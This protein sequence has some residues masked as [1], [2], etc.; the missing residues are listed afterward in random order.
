MN[1]E[2][3]DDRYPYGASYSPLM[4]PEEEWDEDLRLMQEAHLNLVR[5]GDVH[6]SWDRLEPDR[7]EYR[8]GVLKRFYRKAAE[9]EIGALLSTGASCPPLWLAVDHPDVRLL[10]SRGERY[11]LGS[12][13]HWACIHHPAFLEASDRYL[14]ALARE[15][16]EFP[17]HFGWQ[18]SNEIGFPFNPTREQDTLDLY[19]YCE[20]C[21]E[22]FQGWLRD[23]YQAKDA[24]TEAWAWGTTNFVYRSWDEASPPESLPAS[25]SGVTRWIDWRLFW[26]D[27]FTRFARRQHDLLGD[28]DPDH[29]TSI[30]TF[31]FKGYDRF[32]TFTGLDQWKLAEVVDHIGYDLYPGSGDKLSSRPEHNSIFLDHGRSVSEITGK[33]YWLHEV[34]SGPIGGWLLGPDHNTDERDIL[35]YCLEGLGHDVKLMLYM[36]WKEWAYQPL[37]WGALVDLKG[38]PTSRWEAAGTLGRF[39]QEQADFLKDAH[40]PR[41]QVAILESKPN[42]I[43]LRGLDQE[44]LLFQA[45]RGAYRAFWE[46]GFQVDFLPTSRLEVTDLSR[47]QV[48]CLP[49]LGLLDEDQAR[50]L[51]TYVAGGGVLM[52]FARTASLD[53]RGWYHPELPVP[54]LGEALGLEVVRPDSAGGESLRFRGEDYRAW[55]S[56]DLLTPA[57][58]TEVAAQFGDG[59]PAVTLARYGQGLGVYLATQADLGEILGSEENVLGPVVEEVEKIRGIQPSIRVLSAR[60]QRPELDPHLLRTGR[61]TW[62]IFSNYLP[63]GEEITFQ[64]TLEQQPEFVREIFPE[65]HSLDYSYHK[66]QLTVS[67]ALGAKEAKILEIQFPQ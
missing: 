24:L 2:G 39:L 48:L 19:C 25:W 6:G 45:Q 9:Y 14:Q 15:V 13:Y 31:N 38:R 18:I 27:A 30:N 61:T 55:K 57:D 1:P 49:L 20:H 59:R 17:N 50:I 22:A 54:S 47:Y 64:L 16:R 60:G 23:K 34:E 28:I 33:D 46:R 67:T 4:F 35:N 7:E 56:R 65:Q 10:S 62:V 52:A 44:E 66:Q 29:P 21:Q 5:I 43:F 36:P 26:Q 53:Q 11:P 3:M 40:P 8:F 32:G 41:A 63:E 12:S 37:H 58:D 51:N 42:A